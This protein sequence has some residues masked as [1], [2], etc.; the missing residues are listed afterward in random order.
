M[1]SIASTPQTTYVAPVGAEPAEANTIGGRIRSTYLARGL[2]RSQL[3]R[4]LGVAYTTILAWERDQAAPSAENLNALSVV[5]GVTPSFLLGE[6]GRV[7]EP[8]YAAWREFLETE[9][10]RGMTSAERRT[11]AS[12][13]MDEA[14][15]PS[16]ELYRALL[17]GL[18]M[19]R[20][21]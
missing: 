6:E 16:V 9:S 12:M 15:E 7:T 20:A 19:G 21:Q 13:R 17:L 14:I 10:G 8:Q 5:L 4:A 18:R 11:L 3:Q 2:N 1:P